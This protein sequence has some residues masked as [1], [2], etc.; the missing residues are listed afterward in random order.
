MPF[1]CPE[2]KILER[3]MINQTSI[4]YDLDKYCGAHGCAIARGEIKVPCDECNDNYIYADNINKIYSK[5]CGKDGCLKLINRV[6]A[7]AS[8]ASPQTVF[9]PVMQDGKIVY[10]NVNQSQIVKSAPSVPTSVPTY[11]PIPTPTPTPTPIAAPANVIVN[12]YPKKE[13]SKSLFPSFTQEY[14][15]PVMNIRQTTTPFG[16]C[17]SVQYDPH[18]F[19]K[20]SIM[21]DILCKELGLQSCGYP[22]P[23]PYGGTQVFRNQ[24]LPDSYK[25]VYPNPDYNGGSQLIQLKQW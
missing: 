16:T 12:V 21:A 17:G 23:N 9:I 18:G 19:I 1:L 3:R 11:S 25:R 2:C 4:G 6:P 5:Y 13:E 8:T 14:N 22:R 24:A 15:S 20:K 10:M 7:A